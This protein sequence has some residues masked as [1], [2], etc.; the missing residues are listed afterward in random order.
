MRVLILGADGMIGHAL[1]RRCSEEVDT[2]GMTRRPDLHA[3]IHLHHAPHSSLVIGPEIGSSPAMIR[4]F[5]SVRPSVVVN[6]AGVVKQRGT[7]DRMQWSTNGVAPRQL[8][9]MVTGR[10]C[11]FIHLSTDC[12]FSGRRGSYHEVDTPDAIDSYGTSKLAGEPALDGVLTLRKSA[13]GLE[14]RPGMSLVEW[15]LSRRGA[16]IETL[17]TVMFSAVTTTVLADLL[18]RLIT[19]KPT[20]S[21]L[22]HVASQPL[23]KGHFLRHLIAAWKLNITVDENREVVQDRSLDATSFGQRTGL[24]VPAWDEMLERL[25]AEVDRYRYRRDL[26]NL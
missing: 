6:C 23:S 13:V 9:E 21:G 15:L 2:W 10:G 5:D 17:E 16:R 7:P 11:R 26:E 3:S 12:V 18:V 25:I 22:F 8:A 19:E 4:L 14:I 1:L 24:V 20:L